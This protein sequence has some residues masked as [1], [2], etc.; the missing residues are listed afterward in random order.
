MREE[1][2]PLQTPHHHGWWNAQPGRKSPDVGKRP[3]AKQIGLV[4]KWD[5]VPRRK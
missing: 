2:L 1:T 4:R 3:N 5:E